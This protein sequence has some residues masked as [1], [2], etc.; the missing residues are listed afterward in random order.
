MKTLALSLCL[1]ATLLLGISGLSGCAAKYY[2]AR[3]SPS[4]TEATA[5]GTRPGSQARSVVSLVGV[6]RHDSQTGAPPQ[7]EFRMRVENLGSVPCTLEQ[8]SLQLLSGALEP[9]GAAQLESNDPPLIAAGTSSNF[10]I[11]F[12]AAP[13]RN[14]DDIDLRS[15]NLRWAIAFDGEVITNGMTFEHVPTDAYS[16]TNFSVGVGFWGH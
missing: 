6:R 7:V 11:L 15:L 8:H 10:V 1:A 16:S 9:F 2:D 4:T 14:I 12:P 13:G 3:F 5:S